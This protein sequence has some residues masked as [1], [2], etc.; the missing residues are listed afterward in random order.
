MVGEKIHIGPMEYEFI[1]EV[2]IGRLLNAGTIDLE[3]AKDMIRTRK[4]LSGDE[5]VWLMTVYKKLKNMKP[6]ARKY[7]SSDEAKEGLRGLAIVTE[8]RVD[9]A[10]INFFIAINVVKIDFPMKIFNSE[11]EALAWINKQKRDSV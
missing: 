8:S 6:D 2:M 5:S 7:L 3:L 10:V 11:S 9:R 1:G 4:E